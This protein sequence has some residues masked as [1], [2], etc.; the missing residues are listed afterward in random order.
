V[1]P[2]A[3]TAKDPRELA[4]RALCR[5][6]GVQEDAV[7]EGKPMWQSYLPHVNVVLTSIGLGAETSEVLEHTPVQAYFILRRLAQSPIQVSTMHGFSDEGLVQ[8]LLSRGLAVD[9][10]G[11]L[12]ITAAGRAI[13][14]IAANPNS[15]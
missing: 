15:Q 1:A 9:K 12:S 14:E 13:G 11:V 8:F 7:Q 6:Q 3:D 5:F 2:G 10:D 4:A